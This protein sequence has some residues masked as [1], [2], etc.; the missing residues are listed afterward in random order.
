MCYFKLYLYGNLLCSSMKVIHQLLTA[1]NHLHIFLSAIY[2]Y[3]EIGK[4]SIYIIYSFLYLHFLPTFIFVSMEVEK[5]YNITL[6][7][8]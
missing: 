5:P 2:M 4:K 6:V 3:L 7:V 1:Y 8:F